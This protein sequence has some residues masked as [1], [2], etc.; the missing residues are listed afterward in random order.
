VAI[1][2]DYDVIKS[3]VPSAGGV[4]RSRDPWR[5]L[6]LPKLKE[7]AIKQ[8]AVIV[9]LSTKSSFCCFLY[10]TLYCTAEISVC[11]KSLNFLSQYLYTLEMRTITVSLDD[12]R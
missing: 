11:G 6:P 2:S 4:C 10:R 7:N 8:M 3:S 5:R 9:S 12:K 1:K